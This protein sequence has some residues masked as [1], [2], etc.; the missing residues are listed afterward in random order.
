MKE[1]H[2]YHQHYIPQFYLRNFADKTEKAYVLNR[3]DN[4]ITHSRIKKIGFQNDI[5][6][7]KWEGANPI[8]GKYVLDNQIE[9]KFGDIESKAATIIKDIIDRV[10]TVR[11]IQLNQHSREVLCEFLALLYLRNPMV[12]NQLQKDYSDI[13]KEPGMIP[14]IQV[15]ANL[16]NDIGMGGVNSLLTHS[17]KTGIFDKTI[18]GSPA[19]EEYAHIE[20]MNWLFWLSKEGGFCT[21]DYPLI[22]DYDDDLIWQRVVFPL[23]AKVACVLFEKNFPLICKN[24][25]IEVRP[26][27]VSSINERYTR[28][29]PKLAR[30][31]ISGNEA[32]LLRLQT[33]GKG[34]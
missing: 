10:K 4:R 7:T 29:S 23:S 21:C 14:V 16:L 33:A 2:T 1:N 30:F 5:Y 12:F 18:P 32:V 3:Q 20:S 22:I 8:L 15:V 17:V 26:D 24:R 28:L 27:F 19:Y 31:I 11:E 13:D 34:T 6:E 9:Q 25:V